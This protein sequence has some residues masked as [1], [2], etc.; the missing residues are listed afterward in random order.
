M[1]WS[2]LP[3]PIPFPP[4]VH[5]LPPV[6]NLL[7]R[8]MS[9]TGVAASGELLLTLGE[10]GLRGASDSVLQGKERIRVRAGHLA[11]VSWNPGETPGQQVAFGPSQHLLP[12]PLWLR[13]GS[14]PRLGTPWKDASGIGRV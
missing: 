9:S 1:G 7:L 13:L 5:L 3:T 14:V 12:N 10:A 4:S 2:G 8:A 11:D 6:A